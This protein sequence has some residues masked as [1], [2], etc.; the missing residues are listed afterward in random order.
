MRETFVPTQPCVACGK[1]TPTDLQCQDCDAVI[2]GWCKDHDRCPECLAF[3]LEEIDAE[4]RL[5]S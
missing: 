5:E 4:I 3:V 2:C 1:Q